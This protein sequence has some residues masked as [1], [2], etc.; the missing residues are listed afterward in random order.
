MF[1]LDILDIAYFLP[2]ALGGVLCVI[3]IIIFIK[4]QKKKK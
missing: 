2:F 3:A 1:G 4:Q